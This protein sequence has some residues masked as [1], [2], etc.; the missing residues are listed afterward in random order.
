VLDAWNNLV[1]I[2]VE[3]EQKK[4]SV[5][6]TEFT[7]SPL[8]LRTLVQGTYV[9]EHGMD[10][11]SYSGRLRRVRKAEE[12]QRLK[13]IFLTEFERIIVTGERLS[14]NRI[15]R[16]VNVCPVKLAEAVRTDP[17][18][19]KLMNRYYRMTYVKTAKRSKSS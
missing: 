17:E 19:G 5:W 12:A 6:A 9:G 16:T 4:K 3:R 15:A 13:R 7:S 8:N 11:Q 14:F 10:L 1:S 2:A 18:I